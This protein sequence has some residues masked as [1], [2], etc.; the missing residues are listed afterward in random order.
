[1]DNKI[2][3]FNRSLV[4]RVKEIEFGTNLSTEG[5]VKLNNFVTFHEAVIE[6]LKMDDV[7]V[8]LQND[9]DKATADISSG[10]STTSVLTGPIGILRDIELK[11]P[12]EQWMLEPSENRCR[13]ICRFIRIAVT[14][15]QYPVVHGCVGFSP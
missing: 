1:L 4:F 14:N 11:H 15:Q 9:L 3:E 12:V 6:F 2:S 7:D 5:L 13:C 8:L 10:R